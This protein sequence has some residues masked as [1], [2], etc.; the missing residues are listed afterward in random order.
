MVLGDAR[1]KCKWG[2]K[3][4]W[5]NGQKWIRPLAHPLLLLRIAAFYVFYICR[6]LF[7][8]HVSSGKRQWLRR[9]CRKWPL[10]NMC[11]IV[12][13]FEVGRG[14]RHDHACTIPPCRTP[15]R[16]VMDFIAARLIGTPVAIFGVYRS[17]RWVDEGQI[18]KPAWHWW[19]VPVPK[20]AEKRCENQMKF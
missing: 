8:L 18:V 12:D 13:P 7:V 19:T 14:W 2:N 15:W 3:R 5:P 4:K 11:H 17:W 9:G 6:G 1:D 20:I 10:A 16:V